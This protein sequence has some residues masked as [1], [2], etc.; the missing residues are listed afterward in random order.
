MHRFK[1]ALFNRTFRRHDALVDA[2]S[3]SMPDLAALN[4]CQIMPSAESIA[5]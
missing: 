5:F 1:Y 4:V 3:C 2:I